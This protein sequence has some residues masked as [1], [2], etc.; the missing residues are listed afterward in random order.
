MLIEMFP[1]DRNIVDPNLAIV[2]HALY[3]CISWKPST[4]PVC[5]LTRDYR[6]TWSD[7]SYARDFAI[8]MDNPSICFMFEY[9]GASCQCG[10]N[11]E[12]FHLICRSLDLLGWTKPL[13]KF[14]IP[15]M[16]QILLTLL[17]VSS[18]FHRPMLS[19]SGLILGLQP[20]NEIRRSS[21]DFV[22]VRNE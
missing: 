11:R 17:T 14:P 7:V 20:T 12:L 22:S 2:S 1:S 10:T 8:S 19:F 13:S 15:P 4:K 6:G 9:L 18:Y 3:L 16:T 5:F 21:P